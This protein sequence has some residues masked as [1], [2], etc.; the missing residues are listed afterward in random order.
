M[1]NRW[2]H[3]RFPNTSSVFF[4][5]LSSFI[6]LIL[7]PILIFGSLAYFLFSNALQ[8]EVKKN[9]EI[10]LKH[11]FVNIEQK[12]EEIRQ[13][14]YQLSLTA[15]VDSGNPSKLL[16][17]S[18]TLNRIK[19]TQ[20][21]IDD[22]YVFYKD[23]NWIITESGL[24]YPDY[25]FDYVYKSETNDQ[26]Q[27]MQKLHD[28]NL[29]RDLGTFKLTDGSGNRYIV[30]LSSFPLYNNGIRGT[31]VVL[32]NE[33]KFT[34]MMNSVNPSEAQTGFYILNDQLQTIIESDTNH[35][36]EQFSE[37][38]MQEFLNETV[39]ESPA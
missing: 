18:K 7:F 1:K 5:L 4:K 26:E 29:F 6:V 33:E 24:F 19:G 22:V 28:R 25:F 34:S 15:D 13:T 21:F 14:V 2:L 37:W 35:I 12:M 16:D 30:V 31:I 36:N 11:V 17:V 38:K 32:I 3:M 10:L 23:T 8:E 27:L 39:A 20:S 9:N